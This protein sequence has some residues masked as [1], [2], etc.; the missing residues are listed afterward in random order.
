MLG[1]ESGL[2][3]GSSEPSRARVRAISW[4]R[5]LEL[6]NLQDEDLLEGFLAKQ[7]IVAAALGAEIPASEEEVD[8]VLEAA[9]APAETRER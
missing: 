3:A 2:A 7:R 5:V 9:A 6:Q 1:R 8:R 4:K